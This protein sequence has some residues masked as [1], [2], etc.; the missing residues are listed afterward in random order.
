MRMATQ[1][2][3]TSH[4]QDEPELSGPIPVRLD[5]RARAAIRQ[6]DATNQAAIYAAIETLT[7]DPLSDL[8]RTR[9]VRVVRGLH[10]GDG[11]G[12][13][14]EMRVPG[15]ADLRIFVTTAESDGD[16][17]LVVTDVLRRSALQTIAR[18]F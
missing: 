1:A 10:I 2:T 7:H 5:Y 14:Y 11:H 15:A 13:V 3:T 17:T 16:T 6:F 18:S 9:Q 4:V 12:P 8:A